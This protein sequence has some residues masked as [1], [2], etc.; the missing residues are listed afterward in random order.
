M[1]SRVSTVSALVR[2]YEQGLFAV[3]DGGGTIHILRRKWVLQGFNF[4]GQDYAYS[5]PSSDHV[6][7]LTEDWKRDS[8]PVEWGLEPIWQKLSAMDSWNQTRFL[9]EMYELRERNEKLRDRA[10]RGK[11]YDLAKD[12]RKD[13]AREFDFNLGSANMRDPIKE[14]RRDKYGN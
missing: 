7:S 11:F 2:K 13:F 12:T 8:K 4:Q 10:R 9:D 6:V 5:V 14:K 3:R 1:D